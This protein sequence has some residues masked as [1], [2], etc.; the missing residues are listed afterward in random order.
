MAIGLRVV[1]DQL[2]KKIGESMDRVELRLRKT[3]A[4]L[5]HAKIPFAIVGETRHGR[6]WLSQSGGLGLLDAGW[7]AMYPNTLGER[8]RSLIE[9]PEQ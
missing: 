8:L 7:I 5:E 4:I 6:K 9:N 1:G 3:V 2:W